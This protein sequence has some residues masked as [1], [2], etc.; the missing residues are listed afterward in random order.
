[1]VCVVRLGVNTPVPVIGEYPQLEPPLAHGL[2]DR[3]L[4]PLARRGPEWAEVI[5][6]RARSIRKNRVER[7]KPCPRCRRF[8]GVRGRYP[9][10]QSIGVVARGGPTSGWVPNSFRL[11]RITA[12]D[13]SIQAPPSLKCTNMSEL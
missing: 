3:V 11:A 4:Q 12:T 7:G 8:A 9:K 10:I 2:C 1:M 5:Q 6:E 13:L